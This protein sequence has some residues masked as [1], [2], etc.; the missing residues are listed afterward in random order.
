[1]RLRLLF[2]GL[3]LLL[4]LPVLSPMAVG[5]LTTGLIYRAHAAWRHRRALLSPR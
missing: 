2:A 5:A 1:M 4:E 3:L